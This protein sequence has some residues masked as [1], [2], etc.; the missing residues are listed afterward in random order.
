MTSLLEER[1]RRVLRLLP[2]DFR[3]EWADDMAATFMARAYRSAPEDLEG[4][5]ISSPRWP[6]MA[7]I[8]RLAIR[9]RLGGASAQPR[10][11]VTGEAVRRIALVGLLAHAV[12]ALS[13]V[14]LTI[15]FIVRTELP[16]GTGFA[17]WWQAL[18]SMSD[19]LWL[20]AYLAIVFGYRRAAAC[21]ALAAFGPGTVVL[22]L[23]LRAADWPYLPY[24][25][26]WLVFGALPI[27]A[28]VAF[29]SGAPTVRSGPWVAAIP[30]G[31]VL[32]FAVMLVAGDRTTGI[33]L[34]ALGVTV[35]GIV[36]IGAAVH[37]RSMPPTWPLTL[38]VLAAA[39][40]GL[41]ATTGGFDAIVLGPGAVGVV[42]AAMAARGLWQLRSSGDQR[43]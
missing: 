5:E 4:V 31:V 40:L 14:L 13:G 7:S 30:A 1:Y 17:T 10:E 25:I 16:D 34:W 11:F 32:L 37:R 41:Q 33:G 27:V 6:E 42:L 12:G 36:T 38:A 9:L 19:L 15:W 26:G 29:H 39:V 8:A 35:A 28:L 3:H 22:L 2:A 20:P 24:Q 21:I 23:N 18:V 43:T